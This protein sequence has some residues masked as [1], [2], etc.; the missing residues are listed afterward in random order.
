[1]GIIKNIFWAI[2]ILIALA[3][4]F[5]VGAFVLLGINYILPVIV[6]GGAGIFLLIA[7]MGSGDNECLDK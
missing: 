3:I 7:I 6:A 1:V 4:L 2:A 5:V